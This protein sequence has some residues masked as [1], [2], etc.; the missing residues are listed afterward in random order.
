M[1][2]THI[3]DIHVFGWR[4]DVGSGRLDPNFAIFGLRIR[5]VGFIPSRKYNVYMWVQWRSTLL[6]TCLA[7]L[8]GGGRA[9]TWESSAFCAE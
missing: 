6:L 5:W 1:M 3:L 7:L 9:T 8:C 2:I 4:G